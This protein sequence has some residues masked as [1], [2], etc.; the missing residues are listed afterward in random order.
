MQTRSSLRRESAFSRRRCPSTTRWSLTTRPRKRPGNARPGAATRAAIRLGIPFVR[1]T[2]ADGRP[3][4]HR[5]RYHA[6][7]ALGVERLAVLRLAGPIA[8]ELFCGVA[9]DG[10]DETDNRMARGYL[11]EHSRPQ[12][13][14]MRRSLRSRARHLPG[15][16]VRCARIATQHIG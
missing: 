12:L 16:S 4:L 2:I 13:A 3:H 8:E 6:P 15:R 9:G 7:R 11:S 5:A 14:R 1:V 10:C